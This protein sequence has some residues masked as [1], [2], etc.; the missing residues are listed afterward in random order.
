MVLNGEADGLLQINP[1]PERNKLYDFSGPLLKS[2]F[3]M[4]V[5]SD[6]VTLRSI[7]DLRGK[8]SGLRPVVIQAFYLEEYEGN[9]H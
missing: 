9:R 7:D 1:S 3:S 4:F 5:Q 2:E 8:M 6:N